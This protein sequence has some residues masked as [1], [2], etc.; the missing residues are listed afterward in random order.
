VS[1]ELGI[2]SKYKIFTS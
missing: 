2:L 1:S